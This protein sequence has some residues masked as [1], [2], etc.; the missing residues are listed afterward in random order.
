MKKILNLVL[1]CF[2]IILVG[3]SGQ[4]KNKEKELNNSQ[5]Q[6]IVGLSIDY[7]PFEFKNGEEIQGLDVDLAKLIGKQLDKKIVFKELSNNNL[8]TALNAGQID[9]VISSISLTKERAKNFDLSNPYYIADMALIFRKER[10]IQ[11]ISE[12]KNKKIGVQA[13]S[14][15]ETWV[16]ELFTKVKLVTMDLNILLIEALKSKQVDVVVVEYAQAKEFCNKNPDLGYLLASK[17]NHSY[18]VAIKKG[19]KQLLK[20]INAALE[21][22]K[23]Q[24]KFAELEHEWLEVIF[25]TEVHDAN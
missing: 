25:E 12:L 20:Q 11:K 1:Y 6:L 3:C 15:M 14:T 17:S 18:V 7:P 19:S 22:I 9:L 4:D 16:K 24:G 5:N 2:L 23:E 8:F 21:E 10:P 13:G